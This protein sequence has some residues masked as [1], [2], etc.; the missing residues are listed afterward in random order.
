VEG[1]VA[2]VD[3]I[4]EYIVEFL[5]ELVVGVDCTCGEVQVG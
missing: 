5:V 3:G 1:A 2:V 4:G